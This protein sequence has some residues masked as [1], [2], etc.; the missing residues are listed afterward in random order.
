MSTD[1]RHCNV[2]ARGR[3]LNFEEKGQQVGQ[4]G[5]ESKGEGVLSGRSKM[6]VRLWQLPRARLL[7][8]QRVGKRQGTW[9]AGYSLEGDLGGRSHGAGCDKG[10][11]RAGGTHTSV[12]GN[13]EDTRAQLLSLTVKELS[14][15][16]PASEYSSSEQS[17]VVGLRGLAC[18]RL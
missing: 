18:G 1:V 14:T 16:V 7:D 12:V 15:L 10:L 5:M 13:S 9:W 11:S 8:V 3:R 6:H 17:S 4:D 2:I